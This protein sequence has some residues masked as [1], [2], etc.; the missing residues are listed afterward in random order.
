MTERLREVQNHPIL[1]S[2]EQ[3]VFDTPEEAGHVKLASEGK[4]GWQMPTDVAT[5]YVLRDCTGKTVLDL[6]CGLGE[7]VTIPALIL[8]A[9]HVFALDVTREHLDEASLLAQFAR[10]H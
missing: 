9:A 10:Q 8:G 2:Y 3:V 7:T 6:G 4:Y 1:G 5:S